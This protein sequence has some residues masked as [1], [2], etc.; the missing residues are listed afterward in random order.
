[1]D[2]LAVY[3][4]T[5]LEAAPLLGADDVRDRWWTWDGAKNQLA[6]A[7]YTPRQ[8]G[9]LARARLADGRQP[10]ALDLAGTLVALFA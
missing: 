3:D 10:T 2:A 6:A 1:M 4:M 8:L 5:E 9:V 7:D